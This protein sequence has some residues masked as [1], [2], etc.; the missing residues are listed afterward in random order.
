MFLA[1]KWAALVMVG[2][3][4]TLLQGACGQGWDTGIL[5]PSVWLHLSSVFPTQ[6][7]HP[8]CESLW[9]FL[10]ALTLWVCILVFGGRGQGHSRE[11]LAS[12]VCVNVCGYVVCVPPWASH[13]DGDL[14][15]KGKH[16]RIYVM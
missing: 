4:K 10:C 9:M 5:S 14:C 7:M 8:I 6:G 2:K 3:K 13:R 1:G 11:L 12:G 16:S 15:V